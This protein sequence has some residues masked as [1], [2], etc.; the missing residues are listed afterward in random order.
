MNPLPIY[1]N[2]QPENTAAP[3]L[4]ALLM[5]RGLSLEAAFA[6]AINNQF[7]PRPRWPQTVLAAGDRIDIIAPITGG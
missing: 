1:V 4:Q 5:A 7:V 6:C 3:D 2:G